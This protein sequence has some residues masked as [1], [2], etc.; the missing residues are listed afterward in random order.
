MGFRMFVSSEHTTRDMGIF[1]QK[2]CMEDQSENL[3]WCCNVAIDVLH[4]GSVIEFRL[5]S[6][7]PFSRAI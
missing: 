2:D 7:S 3:A 1:L 4:G 6:N 5:F